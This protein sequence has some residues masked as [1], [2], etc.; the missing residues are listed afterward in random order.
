M[1]LVQH[2]FTEGLIDDS[3]RMKVEL[4]FDEAI[5]NAVIHGNKSDFQRTV[6]VTLWR[7]ERSWGAAVQDEGDGFS[8][9][10]IANRP[11]EES[12]WQE[13]GRGI[14]LMTLYMDEVA[15]Y[16]GGRT[17]LLRHDFKPTIAR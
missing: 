4:C 8:L 14:P 1:R 5:T 2:L 7:D 9:E 12:L 11:A 16:D 3:A 13:D 6:K 15:Y 17:L 10:E